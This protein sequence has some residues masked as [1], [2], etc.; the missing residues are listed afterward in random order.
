MTVRGPVPAD[1]LGVT[2][3]HEHIL[4]EFQ[5]HPGEGPQPLFAGLW[6]QPVAIDILGQLRR[7]IWS[8]RDN[9]CLKDPDLAM[10]ELLAFKRAGGR[11]VV[12]VTSVG[13]GRDVAGVRRLAER[14]GLHVVVGTGYYVQT[15]HP[16]QVSTQCIEEIVAWMVG[17]VEQGIEGT[18]A[19]AGIIGEIGVSQSLREDEEK[20]LRAAARAHRQTGAPLSVH[21]SVG[22]TAL[23]DIHRVLREE[24]VPPSRVILSHMDASVPRDALYRAADW[25]Y[26]LSF[27]GFGNEWY[28][29]SAR[30][31]SPRD[32]D[33]VR[34]LQD[35]L[36]RGHL[37]QLLL[38]HNV[39]L[40]M[41]LTRYG[42]WGYG[43]L[44]VNVVPFMRRMGVA[45]K[46]IT[47][48]L[49]YNAARAFAFID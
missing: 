25:G 49:I 19:R 45:P 36:N 41:L 6:Q 43:H 32:V 11:T 27:D 24:E 10:E 26:Y 17:E 2:L 21:V 48:M 5:F 30:S 4:S 37:R 28:D 20:V 35:L 29:D 39:K 9:L 34:G 44:L 33:R 46:Q 13:H 31:Q 7:N 18:P 23:L 12:D 40:K 8:C 38:G 47:T 22:G 16:P 14:T 42:G 1:Q 3:T 15:T